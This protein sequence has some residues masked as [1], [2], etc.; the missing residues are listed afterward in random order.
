MQHMIRFIIIALL[1]TAAAA[2]PFEPQVVVTNNRDMQYGPAIASSLAVPVGP[3]K[4]DFI[5]RA[6]SV[7]LP[8]DTV[9]CYDMDRFG[10]AAL[11][12]GGTL[13]FSRSHHTRHKGNQPLSPAARPGMQQL[14]QPGWIDPAGDKSLVEQIDYH[15][16]YQHGDRVVLS[17]T[18]DGR[19]VLESAWAVD[20]SGAVVVVRH[21]NI[22]EGKTSQA[23]LAGK[24]P[25]RKAAD[26]KIELDAALAHGFHVIGK[27][28]ADWHST[29][30]G[31]V[32][33]KLPARAVD[34]ALAAVLPA[35]GVAARP[36]G[37]SAKSINEA[38]KPLDLA[39]WTKGGP[40]RYPRKLATQ[41][42]LGDGDAAYVNDTITLPNDNPWKSWMRLSDLAFFDDGT[43]AVATLPGD[44]WL[45]RGLDAKLDKVTWQRIATGLYEPLGLEVVDDVIHVLGRDRI[46]KLRDLNGD[47][48]TDFYEN[49]YTLG[50]PG[51]GYHAF[52]FE[53]QTD[54]EGNFY[55]AKGGRK[56]YGGGEDYNHVVR[57]SPD[58]KSSEPIAYGFRH[59]NGMGM[60]PDGLI[61]IADNEGDSIKGSGISA[62][63]EGG[64][65][66]YGKATSG[67]RTQPALVWIPHSVDS[68]CGGQ[69]WP[70]ERFG[71]LAGNFVHTSYGKSAALYGMIQRIDGKPVQAAVV[72]FPFR[73]M[74]G[75]MRP[76]VGPHDGQVYLAGLKGW[77]TNAVKDGCLNRIRYTGKPAY[78]VNRFEVAPQGVRLG[79]TCK[80]D[81]AAAADIAN[82][83]V[84]VSSQIGKKA[85]YTDL[86]VTDAIVSDDGAS[87][88][89]TAS[90]LAP[91]K[92][93][94]IT[95]NIKAADGADIR[96]TIHGT[97]NVV[98]K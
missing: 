90:K 79:F 10:P 71:P 14:N 59:P 20:L 37:I 60:S 74:S 7:V 87:V 42:S 55:Y 39:P 40:A 25:Q 98:P 76:A 56:A 68:S 31:A 6:L 58:G 17:Y 11:W 51:Y 93:I 26:G 27:L 4:A 78:L 2:E 23:V 19:R 33:F 32:Y 63:V 12:T 53:L 84:Q 89:L 80:L 65:Y 8:H 75:V 49:F 16:R 28:D 44:V 69:A 91:A 88:L 52:A 21:F 35:P 86:K 15:G 9:I 34:F 95:C 97:I 18:V 3:K 96:E 64:Y 54:S 22:A 94:A 41:G 38:V 46:T 72:K 36:S 81:S 82:Y 85:K 57:V 92:M 48:E 77:D 66:G 30:N 43:L 1:A 13:N 5:N 24:P 45:V 61:T 50:T 73:F 47:G 67:D 62:V 83:S 29:D 70:G